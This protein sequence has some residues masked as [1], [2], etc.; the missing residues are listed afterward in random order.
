MKLTLFSLG[1][2][3]ISF[4]GKAQVVD[5][6]ADGVDV[7]LSSSSDTFYTKFSNFS[8]IKV[9]GHD[10]GVVWIDNPQTAVD[11]NHAD[12]NRATTI[13]NVILML[14]DSM[15]IDLNQATFQPQIKGGLYLG[16]H[17]EILND[18]AAY[19]HFGPNQQYGY[20]ERFVRQRSH[21]VAPALKDAERDMLN[22]DELSAI[23]FWDNTT[24]A[25]VTGHNPDSLDMKPGGSNNGSSANSQSE[26]STYYDPADQSYRYIENHEGN[27][28]VSEKF[29]PQMIDNGRALSFYYGDAGTAYDENSVT[30]DTIHSRNGFHDGDISLPIQNNGPAGAFF[31][32]WHLIGNPYKSSISVSSF[33]NEDYTVTGGNVAGAENGYYGGRTLSILTDID[34]TN[35]NFFEPGYI[36]VNSAGAVVGLNNDTEPAGFTGTAPTVTSLAPGQGFFIFHTYEPTTPVSVN[37]KNSMRLGNDDD[38][39]MKTSNEL[40]EPMVYVDIKQVGLEKLSDNESAL[41]ARRQ[42]QFAIALT[43]NYDPKK[44][45]ARTFKQDLSV[46]PDQYLANR[47]INI[48]T[49]RKHEDESGFAIR[50]VSTDYV[51]KL[52][53]VG[54]ESKVNN[55]AF[56]MYISNEINWEG[57]DVYVVDRLLNTEHNMTK[58]GAYEFTIFNSGKQQDRFFLKFKHAEDSGLEEVVDIYSDGDYVFVSSSSQNTEIEQ[59]DLYD[60]TGRLVRHLEPN[61]LQFFQTNIS[62]LP[63]AMYMVRVIAN[64]KVYNSKALTKK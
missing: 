11:M 16:H 3:L 18:G 14:S 5:V 7:F 32:H 50:T 23:H 17:T 53:P 45:N 62:N 2:C 28:Y 12:A 26:D 33:L 46:N 37:F 21:L 42:N 13:E 61:T 6:T 36:V 30:Y 55:V 63:K 34:N 35:G 59:I 43:D 48:Y 27:R 25:W 9:T 24:V 40:T 57:Y 38:N 54:F 47:D 1:L 44:F 64:G 41:K 20:K 15:S 19:A 29:L 58:H 31:R 4:L 22:F 51:N 56:E 60:V 52:I 39:L 8:G 49:Q 10:S